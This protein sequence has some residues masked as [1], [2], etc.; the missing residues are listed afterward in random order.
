MKCCNVKYDDTD[1]K[2]EEKTRSSTP[3]K[4]FFNIKIFTSQ[5]IN[6]KIFFHFKKNVLNFVV[7]YFV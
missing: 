5:S 6:T 4:R 7:E 1:G 3:E 2:M